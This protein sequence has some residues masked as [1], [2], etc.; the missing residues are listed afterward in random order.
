VKFSLDASPT[1]NLLHKRHAGVFLSFFHKAFRGEGNG[2]VP[3]ERLESLWDAFIENEV[4]QSDWE[5]DPPSNAAKFY[6]EDWCKSRWMS[7]Q[8]SE[9]DGS[10]LYRLTH[11]ADQALLFVEQ[12]LS[13][14]RRSFVGTESNFSKI[15]HAMA[16]LAQKTQTDPEVRA[17]QLLD[18]R[19]RIDEELAELKRTGKPRVLDKT[20]TKSRVYD[21]VSMTNRFIA[22]FGKVEESFKRQR[23]EVQSL[24]LAQEKSRGDILESAL[25]AVE[26]L[27]DSD[28]G[29]SF[30]G[31]Q[32]MLRSSEDMDNLRKLIEHSQELAREYQ[33][34][35]GFLDGLIGRLLTEVNRAQHTYSAIAK[36]L[37]V[38]VEESFRQ[39]RRLLVE[40]VTE[41][42]KHA[43][44]AREAPPEMGMDCYLNPKVNPV[45]GLNWYERRTAGPLNNTMLGD[46]EAPDLAG[47]FRGIGHDL[48]MREIQ[49][50]VDAELETSSQASLSAILEKNELK[51]G[52]IDL[53]CFLF[54][55]GRHSRHQLLEQ[56]IKFELSHEPHRV[57]RLPEIIYHKG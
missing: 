28:E 41:I 18:E 14:N 52:A 42:K 46:G 26:L 15:L 44:I 34:E 53:L 5:G 49:A 9:K 51:H 30:F 45:M 50:M 21:L 43:H 36:Q 8:F 2:T 13:E 16:E 54:L 17:K 39:D 23:D 55:A 12:H 29:R 37:H 11:H 19:D 40:V 6:V 56:Q 3:E 31:F 48:R 25:D 4:A 57:A 33:V 32:K 24:Y 20:A 27:K 38:V 47:F 7:R 22:D 35:P 10:Y 1:L